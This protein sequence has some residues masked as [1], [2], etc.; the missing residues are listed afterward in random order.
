VPCASVMISSRCMITNPPAVTIRPPFDPRANSVT[1]RSI[2]PGS[3][4]PRGINSTRKTAPQIGWRPTG[5]SR[6]DRRMPKD[7]H[8]RHAGRDLFEQL[9]PL[10]ADAVL[11]E[12]KTGG[13]AARP[14]HARDEAS[15]DWVS[16]R[17][18][19]DWDD[20]CRL[21]CGGD[22]WH[23]RRDND[24][25][26]ETTYTGKCVGRCALMA[27]FWG[28]ALISRVCRS[29]FVCG[30][31]RSS[32]KMPAHR[33]RRRSCPYTREYSRIGRA[34]VRTGEGT[35]AQRA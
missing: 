23:S 1:A 24:V 17:C 18:E 29:R 25:Y 10:P 3:R 26:L 11:R 31:R 28:R 27:Y 33:R 20:R 34:C 4:T 6:R 19:H 35:P 13:V 15:A 32:R 5:R 8:S 30:P 9:Q 7:R 14:R 22:L 21:H 16:R 12:G 2:S